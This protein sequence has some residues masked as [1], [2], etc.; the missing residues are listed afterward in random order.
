MTNYIHP[1]DPVTLN[2]CECARNFAAALQKHN[3]NPNKVSNHFRRYMNQKP[4][5]FEIEALRMQA[6]QAEYMLKNLLAIVHRDD[7]AH[8]ETVGLKQSTEDAVQEWVRLRRL[9]VIPCCG[10][11]ADHDIWDGAP[12]CNY[13]Q[14]EAHHSNTKLA[15]LSKPP[16]DWCP[17]RCQ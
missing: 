4:S 13:D 7:G 3:R 17:K 11:C 10:E 2:L 6:T 16:P 15:S 14:H 5:D 8:T 12:Y 1:Q 9:P